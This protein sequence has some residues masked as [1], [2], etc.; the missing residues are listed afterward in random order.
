MPEKSVRVCVTGRA[1]QTR[2]STEAGWTQLVG[3]KKAESMNVREPSCPTNACEV[4]ETGRRRAGGRGACHT[5][6]M[7][8]WSPSGL[9]K[10]TKHGA[11][12]A[13]PL[14]QGRQKSG[15]VVPRWRSGRGAGRSV[16]AINALNQRTSTNYDAAGRAAAAV[17]WPEVASEV[18]RTLSPEEVPAP[19]PGLSARCPLAYQR[20]GELPGNPVA[21]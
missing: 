6:K 5:K 7:A 19:P 8:S 10:P 11:N 2:I 4:S 17:N 18:E 13:G 20:R 1:C 16:A 3:K 21:A 12:A 9:A 14:R 15:E